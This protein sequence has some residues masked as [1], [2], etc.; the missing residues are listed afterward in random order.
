MP[1]WCHGK[2]VRKRVWAEGLFT[3]TVHVEGVKLFEPGQFLHLSLVRDG[4]RINRPYSVASPHGEFLDFF[5]VLVEDG[6]LTPGMWDLQV[7]DRVD[8]SEQAAGRFT[9]TRAP[10]SRTLWLM[11]TGT[12][13]A[14]YIAMLRTAQPW[15]QYQQIC[16]VHGVR[17]AADL[18]YTQELHSYNESHAGRFQ[19]IQTLTREKAEGC[20]HGRIPSLLDSGV[21]ESV[22]GWEITPED[23][24]V[25]LCGNPAMLDEM[26]QRLEAR[27][28]R[29]HRSKSPGQIVLERYW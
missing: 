25:M 4:E 19:L 6:K 2:V 17:H 11:A 13:L 5:I 15:D 22:T 28:L 1:N 9:L 29:E 18:A 7:E 24:T 27:G 21:L 12:G 3:L 23:S 8:V 14:P 16:L 20:Q 26:E 10:V